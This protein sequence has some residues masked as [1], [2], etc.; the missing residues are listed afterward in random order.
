MGGGGPGGGS[1]GG[2]AGMGASG[3]GTAAP[4]VVDEL[5]GGADG[6]GPR[7]GYPARYA[8]GGGSR[9]V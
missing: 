3:K 2:S 8:V 1:G 5:G 4:V 7:S 6:D 9:S